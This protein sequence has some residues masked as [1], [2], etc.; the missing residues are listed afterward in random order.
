MI[1]VPLSIGLDYDIKFTYRKGLVTSYK[2]YYFGYA[3]D[4]YTAFTA[5]NAYNATGNFVYF[6]A[7]K[8]VTEDRDVWGF[9]RQ[10]DRSEGLYVDYFGSEFGTPSWKD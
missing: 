7:L 2:E 9:D 6:F 8:F 3:Y 4:S 1:H 10:Q 5:I